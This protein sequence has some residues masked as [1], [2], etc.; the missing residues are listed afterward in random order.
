MSS[1]K[2]TKAGHQRV[3]TDLEMKS[4]WEV[5]EAAKKNPREFG[6]LY[7][8]YY[9][10]IFKFLMKRT[11]NPD[12]SAELCSQTFLKA[13]KQIQNYEF[14]GVPFSAWLFRIASNE[15]GQFYRKSNKKR[16]VSI[17]DE[18]IPEIGMEANLNLER[19]DEHEK[20][21]SMLIATLDELKEKDLKI[22]EMRFFEQRPFK[23]IAQI[24]EITESNAKMKT[25]RI[26]ERMKKKI[27][28][29]K[30]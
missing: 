6:V 19:T 17:E 10:P 5:I 7:N 13:M 1:N 30:R 15:L 16:V 24:L 2:K 4:E 11:A 26:L 9:T 29:K 21:R 3:V 20:L 25:Y 12:L 22:I 23:E 28:N 18:F 8:K 14:R 27:D